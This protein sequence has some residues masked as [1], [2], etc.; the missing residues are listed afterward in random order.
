MELNIHFHAD[1]ESQVDNPFDTPHPSSVIT[2]NKTLQK[3]MSIDKPPEF[4]SEPQYLPWPW[5]TANRAMKINTTSVK[6][7][8]ASFKSSTAGIPDL[9]EFMIKNYGI[10]YDD[11]LSSTLSHPAPRRPLS[12]SNSVYDVSRPP[13]MLEMRKTYSQDHLNR[14]KTSVDNYPT[15][16][17]LLSRSMSQND[18]TRKK[19]ISNKPFPNN[20]YIRKPP[21]KPNAPSRRASVATFKNMLHRKNSHMLKPISESRERIPTPLKFTRKPPLPTYMRPLT[22][23]KT[24]L[25]P[26]VLRKAANVYSGRPS[27]GKL[28]EKSR[29]LL[30]TKLKHQKMEKP[31]RKKR[32][33]LRKKRSMWRSPFALPSSIKPNSLSLKTLSKLK[34]SKVEPIKN[35]AMLSHSL[36]SKG[37][38]TDE[39]TSGTF[40]SA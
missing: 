20:Q 14:S 2:N 33:I 4:P 24:A 25:T 9:G 1:V 26:K 11:T 39:I 7:A 27:T 30:Q 36:T 15:P 31:T 21:T 16:R 6:S 34:H 3:K 12:R 22:R 13:T 8:T 28:M 35:S 19:S 29:S 18:I 17:T 5:R 38:T 32:K 37:F 23:S 40:I 10:R